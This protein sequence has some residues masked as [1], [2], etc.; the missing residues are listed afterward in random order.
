MALF[1]S[2]LSQLFMRICLTSSSV[3]SGL[4]LSIN[5]PIPAAKGVADDVPPKLLVYKPSRSPCPGFPI[6]NPLFSFGI[7]V[8]NIPLVPP[9]LGA[10]KWI[11][12]P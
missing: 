8:V 2:I 3:K 4:I 9:L 7:S 12:G 10:T 5:A 11:S 6:L 1:V